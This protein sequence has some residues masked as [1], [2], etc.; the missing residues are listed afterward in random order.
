MPNWFVEFLYVLALS[1]RTQW[2]LIFGVLIPV[3]ILI[4]GQYM[5][6]NFELFGLMK[7][8]EDII[9]DK[10]LRKYDKVALVA[11]ISFLGLAIKFYL[12]DKDRV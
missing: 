3:V 12:K 9:V 8:F 11:F 4:F 1:K 5:T 2:A 6:N 10:I 7:Q